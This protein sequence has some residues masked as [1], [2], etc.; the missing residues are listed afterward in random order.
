MANWVADF[1]ERNPELAR[2]PVHKRAAHSLH[3][4]R[5]DGLIVAQFTGVPCHY[6]DV[7]TGWQPLDTALRL[8]GNEYGAP[9]LPTRITV[10]GGV[11]LDK[12]TWQQRTTGLAI[13][14]AKTGD[15]KR[16]LTTL[17]DGH[18]DGETMVRE[19]GVFRHVLRLTET[20][21]RETL[22]INEP[23]SGTAANEWAILETKVLGQ[24]WADGQLDTAPIVAGVM[25][26]PPTCI[27][28]AGNAAPMRRYA[29]KDGA[30]QYLYTGVPLAWLAGASYPVT[31]D[32][33]YAAMAADGYAAGSSS[34]YAT[35]RGTAATANIATPTSSL[36]QYKSAKGDFNIWRSFLKF[37]TSAIPAGST[38]NQANLTL[39]CTSDASTLNDFDVVIRKQNWSAYDPLTTGSNKEGAFDECLGAD[40]DDNIWRNTSGISTNTQYASGNL[41]T[42]WPTVAGYTYYSLIS[43]RDRDANEPGTGTEYI[44]VALSENT[45]STYRPF[46]TVTYTEGGGVSVVPI[47][48]NQYRLRG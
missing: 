34:S 7:S 10:D 23:L 38:V 44:G 47:I 25:F 2:L 29:R 21:L 48:M 14:D 16:R 32:P 42:A 8:I 36:G 13:L 1:L 9:G 12:T 26:R 17:P 22:T 37:D 11:R 3:F 18:I 30:V 15:I 43:S 6:L 5:P 35:A 19:F 28:A 40:S 27:D 39:V 20:G 31:I 4:R 24:D 45:T 46:L 41:S 33:D